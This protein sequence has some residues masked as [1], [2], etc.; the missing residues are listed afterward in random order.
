MKMLNA[1][2]ALAVLA[3]ACLPAVALGHTGAA[4]VS[5]SGASFTW[6]SFGAGSNTVNYRIDVDS[7]PAVHGTFV[8]NESGGT[9]G[10]LTVPMTLYANHRVQ[11]FSW[12]G[13]A[14]TVNGESRPASSPALADRMVQCP[15]APP[16]P[17]AT[18]I[19]PAPVPAAAPAA[20]AA[21]PAATPMVAVAGERVTSAPIARLAVQKSC[22]VQSARVTV[23]AVQMRQVRLSVKGRRARTVT[24][25]PGA[26]RVTTLVAL[27]RHGAAVQKVTTRITFRNGAPARTLVAVARRCSPAAVAPTFTG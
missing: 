25:A 8:L 6:V 16:A 13:P 21:P 12:W 24:V 14:G 9:A 2:A 18:P 23:K 27:R 4:T 5:C 22:A 11:A 10:H 1:A 17:I 3:L 7:A 20:A 15:A 19:A 26:R